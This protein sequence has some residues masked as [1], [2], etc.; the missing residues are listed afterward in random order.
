MKHLT[1]LRTLTLIAATIA[2]SAAS[3]AAEGGC[4]RPARYSETRSFAVSGTVVTAPGMFDPI[5]QGAYNPSA[6]D[7]AGQTLHGDHAYVFYQTGKRTRAAARH[8]AVLLHVSGLQDT[9][10]GPI[11]LHSP[12]TLTGFL[13]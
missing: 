4:A 10:Q 13:W 5:K 9:D 1:R 12:S 8:V 2:S 11:L 7:P 3:A 6:L